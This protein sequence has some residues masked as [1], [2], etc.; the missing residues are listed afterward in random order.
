MTPE[1]VLALGLVFLLGCVALVAVREERAAR[2]QDTARAVGSVQ[3]FAPLPF[4]AAEAGTTG[5]GR[6]DLGAQR[7]DCRAAPRRPRSALS[8]RLGAREAAT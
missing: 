5:L 8:A 6:G 7:R 3:G 4:G 2:A 1:W